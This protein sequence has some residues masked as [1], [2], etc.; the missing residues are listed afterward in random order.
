VDKSDLHKAA[1]REER[2]WL[3]L[4]RQECERREGRGRERERERERS[5]CL[6]LSDPLLCLCIT[7]GQRAERQNFLP[8]ALCE[9]ERSEMVKGYEKKSYRTIAWVLQ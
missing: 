1:Q 2:L 9:R 6:D 5:A 4:L 8:G 3:P 7:N